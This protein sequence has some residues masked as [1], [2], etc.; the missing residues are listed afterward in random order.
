MYPVLYM[1][2]FALLGRHDALWCDSSNFRTKNNIHG[3]QMPCFL[4]YGETKVK[5]T[6]C[7]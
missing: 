3:C 5:T 1:Y 2:I 6:L 7:H 4:T